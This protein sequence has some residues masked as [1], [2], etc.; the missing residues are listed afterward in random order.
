[1]AEPEA[2]RCDVDEAQEALGGLVVACGHPAGVLE[3]VEAAFD[4][5]AQSVKGAV[6]GQAPL[7]GLA[8]WDHRYDVAR[9]HGFANLIRVIAAICQQ[10]ARFGQIVVHDQIEAQIVRCLTRR[11]VRPLGQ[12]CAVDAEVDLGREATSRTAKTLLRSPPFAPAA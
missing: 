9:F 5:V 8:H 2:D 10:D 7:A 1:M 11:D 4:E 12:A 6:H 3:L